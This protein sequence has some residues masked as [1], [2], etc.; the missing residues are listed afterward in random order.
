[1]AV[2]QKQVMDIKVAKGFSQAQSDEHKRNWS[3]KRWDV[4]K[5]YGAYDRTR[6]HLN[7]EIVKGK[8]VPVDKTKSVPER[9]KESLASHGIADPNEG[10]PEPKYRTIVNIIFGGSRERMHELAFGTQKVDLSKKDADN[11]HITRCEDIEKWALD[12]YNFAAQKWGEENIASFVVHLDETNPHC[13]CTL[14]P[15]RDN[16]FA[17]KKIFAGKDLYDYKD[18]MRQLHDEFAVVNQKWGLARGSDIAKTGARNISPHEFRRL[19]SRDCADLETQIATNKSLLRQLSIEVAHAEKRVKGLNTMIA[20]LE[21]QKNDLEKEMMLV[22]ANL[23]AGYGDKDALQKQVD[24]LS[25]DYQKIVDALADK[26]QKLVE[27]NKKLAEYRELEE[28]SRERA[29]EYR[30]QAEDYKNEVKEASSDLT[31]QVY[32][33]I[34]D[35]LVGDIISELK[36]ILP[37]LGDAK[38]AFDSTLLEDLAERGNKIV[39]CAGYLFAGYVD[40]ATQFAQSHGGGGTSNDLPWGRKDD[41]DDLL[42]ARRCLFHAAKMMRPRGGKSVKRK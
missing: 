14:L 7:F 6:E 37:T 40:G 23:R 11:S 1:M 18:K 4:G 2:S 29:S 5:S 10:L 15:I 27:A 20:N 38:S 41:E 17:Y 28:Q 22:S 16:K 34:K 24:K 13:H 36:S 35:A 30:Q 3:D 32:F 12:V 9:I 8:I 21:N 25:L 31:Q 33:R 42:W 39:K 19:L 26:R